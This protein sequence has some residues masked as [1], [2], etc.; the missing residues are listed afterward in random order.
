M[1]QL[2]LALGQGTQETMEDFLRGAETQ[3]HGSTGAIAARKVF[4]A[5]A[6]M[7]EV[8]EVLR[9]FVKETDT[10]VVLPALPSSGKAPARESGA[11]P[12]APTPEATE[13]PAA[14]AAVPVAA[15]VPAAAAPAAAAAASASAAS[16]SAAAPAMAG[17]PNSAIATAQQQQAANHQVMMSADEAYMNVVQAES[18]YAEAAN[19]QVMMSADEAYMNVVQAES[20]YAEVIAAPRNDWSSGGMG[21]PSPGGSASHQQMLADVRNQRNLALLQKQLA[22]PGVPGQSETC[23]KCRAGH[24]D[25]NHPHLTCAFW[26]CG[27]CKEAGHRRAACQNPTVP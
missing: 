8:L 11:A 15:A 2:V 3:E 19:H 7:G 20:G 13:A 6:F 14:A 10:Y 16:A 24:R 4:G 27:N 23:H 1:L 12:P 9:D 18:G 5:R 25:P 26:I 21:V 17:A 22:N